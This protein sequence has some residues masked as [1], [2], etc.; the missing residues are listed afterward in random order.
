VLAK[1]KVQEDHVTLEQAQLQAF[2]GSVNA[3]GTSLYLAHDEEPF[4]VRAKLQGVEAEQALALLGKQ[5]VLSGA[6]DAELKLDGPGLDR[7]TVLKTL[8]GA[9]TGVLKDGKFHG[10]DLVA[11]VAGP[12]A[13]KLPFAKKVADGGSTSLGKS[14]P[15]DVAIADGVASLRK[16]LAF[17]AGDGKVE[18]QGGVGLDGALKMPGTVAL[19]PELVSKISGGKVKPAAPVPLGFTLAGP[20]WSPH[21]EGLSVDAAAK[22]LATQAATG[23]IGKALGLGAGGGDGKSGQPAKDAQKQLEDA[24]RKKLKGLFGK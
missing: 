19:S 15:F 10:K 8:T 24:A 21:L 4:Q 14:L 16:P 20:A 11:S 3:A 22:S 2:G 9:L 13:A 6:V 5:K 18:L 7:A 1:V 23:A 12:L 17:D